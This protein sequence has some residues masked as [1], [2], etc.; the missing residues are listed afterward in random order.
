MTLEEAQKIVAMISPGLSMFRE[1]FPSDFDRAIGF[2]EGWNARGEKDAGIVDK[3][4]HE[5]HKICSD[6]GKYASSNIKVEILK[7][8]VK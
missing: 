1:E 5:W 6:A 8:Q 2:F 3:E 7:L 4:W